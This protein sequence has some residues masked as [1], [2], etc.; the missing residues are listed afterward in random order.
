MRIDT[1][2]IGKC[3]GLTGVRIGKH[4]S[5]N[6]VFPVDA[7]EGRFVI[8]VVGDW[9]VQELMEQTTN[10]LSFLNSRGIT[11]APALKPLANGALFCQ[12]DGRF[13]YLM[14]RVAGS[15]VPETP[16]SYGRLGALLAEINAVPGIPW[17]FHRDFEAFRAN[18]LKA[19]VQYKFGAYYTGLVKSL[20]SM[21]VPQ[22]P[23]ALVHPDLHL[24]QVMSRPDGSW[25]IIDWDDAGI[26]QR[27][28]SLGYPLI[29]EFISDELEIR[30]REGAAFYAAYAERSPILD[31]E[32][33]H[34]FTAALC[35]AL[36]FLQ[37]VPDPNA[38][39]K[40]IRFALDNRE[41]LLAMLPAR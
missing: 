19:A 38:A 4:L 18:L 3:W 12:R 8:K 10:L 15:A 16:E 2:W 31:I 9:T 34:L 11:W 25:V 17:E 26:G 5:E 37:Y 20:A 1:E 39:W 33:E 28:A 32:R 30:G 21:D 36:S 23:T 14:E 22:L 41:A 29:L 35:P 13:S 7:A 27:V 40:K 24:G 6:E